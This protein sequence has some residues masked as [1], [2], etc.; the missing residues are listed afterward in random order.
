MGG[1]A[2]VISGVVVA[3]RKMS[4]GEKVLAG[5]VEGVVDRTNH[6]LLMTESDHAQGD[7]MT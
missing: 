2:D 3:V 1:L 7:S 4:Q 6:E 5:A